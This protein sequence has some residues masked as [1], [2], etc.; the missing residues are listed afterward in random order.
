G[1]TVRRGPGEA[2]GRG[3]AGRLGGGAAGAGV[4]ETPLEKGR[5]ERLVIPGQDAAAEPGPRIVVAATD[6]AP[7]RIDDRHRRAR[8]DGAHVGHV[9]LEDPGVRA[10]PLAAALEPEHRAAPRATAG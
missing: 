3:H 2:A 7:R 10:R 4:G 8:L 6:E 1:Q 5:V 9:A